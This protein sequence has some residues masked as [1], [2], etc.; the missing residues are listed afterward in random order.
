MRKFFGATALVLLVL[1]AFASTVSARPAK[2]ARPLGNPCASTEWAFVDGNQLLV[3]NG[4]LSILPEMWVL[5][6]SLDGYTY[7]GQVYNEGVFIL[8]NNCD[9]MGGQVYQYSGGTIVG[10][11]GKW[12]WVYHCTH[13]TYYLSGSIWYVSCTYPNTLVAENYNDEGDT[14]WTA[15]YTCR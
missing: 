15:S 12:G 6:S 2:S 5:V 1:S 10:G 3:D 14:A 11:G 13:T 7:C 9:N 4:D 8:H